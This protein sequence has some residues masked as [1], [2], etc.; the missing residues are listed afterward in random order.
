MV[1]PLFFY[2]LGLIA[3]VWLCVMLHWAWPSDP[4]ACPMTLNST[5]PR[6]KRSQAPSKPCLIAPFCYASTITLRRPTQG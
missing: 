6:L 3:L 1:S 5:P 4:A 2:Q